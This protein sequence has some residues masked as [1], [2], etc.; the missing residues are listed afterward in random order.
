[1]SRLLATTALAGALLAAPALGQTMNAAPP[2]PGP[3]SKPQL[4]A[5]DQSFV[6]EAAL[7]G[8]AEVELGKMAEQKAQSRSVKDFGHRMVED[9]GKANDQ[10]AA[11]AKKDALTLP[12]ASDQEYKSTADQLGKQTGAAFDRMYV[13][14]T[15][16]AHRTTAQL[17]EKESRSGENPDLKQFAQQ[18]LPVIQ[19][20]LQM[21][22]AL[23][24]DLN[25][26]TPLS[27]NPRRPVGSTG[28]SMSPNGKAEDNSADQLNRQ[29]L[30]SLRQ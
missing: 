15:V 29:E 26:H 28:S 18:T 5:Q 8:K 16:G 24:A 23:E 14:D 17:F 19:H 11:I 7:D 22:Q 13:H 27:A 1:M 3:A 10:L 25:R 30:D 21:A 2:T 6:R 4:N 12:S 20:H 9:H